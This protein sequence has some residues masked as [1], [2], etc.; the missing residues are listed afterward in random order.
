VHCLLLRP[1]QSNGS[2]LWPTGPR[3]PDCHVS[4]SACPRLCRSIL[5]LIA[6]C[7]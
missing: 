6:S 4:S 7:C 3:C 2:M 1:V 5:S